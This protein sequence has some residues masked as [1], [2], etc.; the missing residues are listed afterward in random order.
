VNMS[1]ERVSVGESV[2][3]GRGFVTGGRPSAASATSWGRSIGP[4]PPR[5][6]VGF[7]LAREK[8]V[9]AKF[10][11]GTERY[12]HVSENQALPPRASH[13]GLTGPDRTGRI[14]P[15]ACAGWCPASP[16]PAAGP[17][18]RASGRGLLSTRRSV[19]DK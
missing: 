11:I 14:R 2:G 15:A 4:R 1:G 12:Q 8:G 10:R 17:E 5:E 7:W 6:V 16:G 9:D 19:L 13:L 3:R 18:C